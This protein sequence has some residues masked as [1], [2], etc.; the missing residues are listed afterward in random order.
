MNITRQYSEIYCDIHLPATD[1]ADVK[2]EDQ[3]RVFPNILSSPG[4]TQPKF[5]TEV[6]VTNTQEGGAIFLL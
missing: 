6:C 2:C 4:I 1:N 5:Y 3:H